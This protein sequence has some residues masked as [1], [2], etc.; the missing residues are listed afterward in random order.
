MSD[1]LMREATTS[2]TEESLDAGA[3]TVE[4]TRDDLTRQLKALGEPTRLKMIDLLMEGVQ[5]NCEIAQRLDLSYSLISHHM[6]VLRLCGLVQSEQSPEDERWV[7]YSVDREA[8]EQLLAEMQRLLD[9][10]RMQ[11]RAPVCGPQG[12]GCSA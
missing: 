4:L 11:P 8:V 1:V 3:A 9:P 7:Y 5:C 10:A 2:I 6:R 12:K